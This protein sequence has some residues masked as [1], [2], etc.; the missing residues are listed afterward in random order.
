MRN[1]TDIEKE[2]NEVVIN[3]V[4][5]N[6]FEIKEKNTLKDLFL[7]EI[8]TLD[9]K[10]LLKDDNIVFNFRSN[11][12]IT[13]EKGIIF[14]KVKDSILTKNKGGYK[15]KKVN[16]SILIGRKWDLRLLLK[17]MENIKK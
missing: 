4:I 5:N 9:I 11:K 1:L 15:I 2:F 13:L 3:K 12:I 7:I 8:D 14:N 10:V 6:D 17:E 16:L